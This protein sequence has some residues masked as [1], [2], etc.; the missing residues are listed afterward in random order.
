[1]FHHPEDVRWFKV[2]EFHSESYHFS[3]FL[4]VESFSVSVYILHDWIVDDGC[5]YCSPWKCGPNVVVVGELKNL[6]VLMVWCS[7][8]T[9]Q[10]F[11]KESDV[12]LI[13]NSL[14]FIWC[15]VKAAAASCISSMIWC[16]WDGCTNSLLIFFPSL[17]GLWSV[18]SMAAFSNMT[19]CA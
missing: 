8:W 16:A 7:F 14:R 19:R 6:L 1:M 10:I 13:L 5:C 4:E 17:Q 9:R 2:K 12:F 11:R 3:S 18:F 15:R